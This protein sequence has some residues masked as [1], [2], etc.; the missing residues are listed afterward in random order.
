[1]T[2]KTVILNQEQLED[3][4]RFWQRILRL[5]DWTLVAE[6]CRMRDIEGSDARTY[7]VLSVKHARIWVGDETD[8]KPTVPLP[9]D[10]EVNLVHELMHL[11]IAQLTDHIQKD[12]ATN[13]AL[14]NAMEQAV[15]NTA[16]AL[17]Y[18]ARRAD[19][20][21]DYYEN[22]LAKRVYGLLPGGAQIVDIR[23]SDEPDGAL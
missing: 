1:M 3:R 18:L 17:V 11:V 21:E 23:T 9:L 12:P 20:M 2:N 10:M 6:V 13:N 7:Y 15:E 19:E 4:T 8:Y 14:H 5:Q 22:E 16:Q